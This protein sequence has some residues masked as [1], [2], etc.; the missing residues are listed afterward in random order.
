MYCADGANSGAI[1]VF[2]WEPTWIATTGNGWNPT[3]SASGDQWDN[4]ALLVGLVVP[5]QL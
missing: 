2:Y 5:I 3:N 4:Q 1:G